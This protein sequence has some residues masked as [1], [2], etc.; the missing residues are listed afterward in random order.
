VNCSQCLKPLAKDK[1]FTV[2]YY[3]PKEKHYKCCSAKCVKKL[4]DR[5][6][7][8]TVKAHANR[9]KASL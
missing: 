5:K 1:G 9:S 8:G 2:S 3:R 4:R 7:G 6:E